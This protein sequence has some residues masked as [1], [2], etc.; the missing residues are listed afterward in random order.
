[1][2]RRDRADRVVI[3]WPSGKVEE[4]KNVVSGRAYECVEGSG[5]KVQE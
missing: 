4:F 2:G 5:L 1:V 3:A